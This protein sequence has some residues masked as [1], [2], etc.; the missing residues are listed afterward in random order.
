MKQKAI[1]NSK[2][3]T[4]S[5]GHTMFFFLNESLYI[6]N[7]KLYE[8]AT[9]YSIFHI[10]E[11]NIKWSFDFFPQTLKKNKKMMLGGFL[12]LCLLHLVAKNIGWPHD[13]LK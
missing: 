1:S 5:S 11:K 6:Y 12:M 10:G 8:V 7:Q 3:Q 9:Q 13:I 4:R 2:E